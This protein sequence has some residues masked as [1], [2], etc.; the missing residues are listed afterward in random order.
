MLCH[1]SKDLIYSLAEAN[2]KDFK[3][4]VRTDNTT[5]GEA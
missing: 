5:V 1:I 3:V 2:D 4:S